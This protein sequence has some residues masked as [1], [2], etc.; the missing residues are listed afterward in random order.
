MTAE[1]VM[2]V[3]GGVML[4]IAIVGGG[5]EL[6]EL[7]VPRVGWGT[8]LVS[9]I[10]GILFVFLGVGM[11]PIAPGRQ[12]SQPVTF[13]IHDE[14]GDNQ[15][16]EQVTI[17]IDGRVVG[18]LAV[19]RQYPSG[20]ITVTVPEAGQHTYTVEARAVFDHEGELFE[21]AGAGQGAISVGEGRQFRLAG[22]QTGSTWLVSLVEPS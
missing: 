4:L 8:R 19:D 18:T 22:S 1:I 9:G 12:A 11:A 5:F 3:L 2:F 7:K 16:S 14:L 13:T 21:L 6:K 20:M 10:A 17:V 15:V